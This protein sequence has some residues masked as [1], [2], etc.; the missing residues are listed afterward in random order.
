MF[1][2]AFQFAAI[3]ILLAAPFLA[4]LRYQQRQHARRVQALRQEM[5]ATFRREL[6]RLAPACKDSAAA[7]K[8]LESLVIATG[9][10]FISG[11][12]LQCDLRAA[13]AGERHALRQPYLKQIGLLLG[14]QRAAIE[15]LKTMTPDQLTPRDRAIHAKAIAALQA[16]QDVM[17]KSRSARDSAKQDKTA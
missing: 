15:Y 12:D 6:E 7:T 4:L 3:I 2:K 13:I 11:E 17:T 14:G 16:L 5:T 9:S 8:L 10:G 1:E